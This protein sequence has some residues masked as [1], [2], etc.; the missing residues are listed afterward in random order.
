MFDE[1]GSAREEAE[2]LVGVVLA[3]ASMA[4]N[5]H[6]GLSTGS[7]ECCVCPLCRV[8]AAV[9]DPDPAMVERLTSGAGDL[10]AGVA[11]FLRHVAAPGSN[12]DSW[13]TATRAAGEAAEPTTAAATGWPDTPTARASTTRTAAARVSALAG[14]SDVSAKARA[15]AA[16]SAPAPTSHGEAGHSPA[17]KPMAKKAVAKKAVAKKAVA[18]KAEAPAEAPADAP[19]SGESPKKTVAKKAAAKKAPPE[20]A[21]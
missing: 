12:R 5:A 17:G 18:P 15:T 9:R 11:S 4:A 10:A 1:P 8:I 21:G 14:T 7:A 6:P 20:K 16:G 3:A 13:H 2:R 19:A